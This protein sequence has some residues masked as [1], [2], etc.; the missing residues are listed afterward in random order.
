LDNTSAL[1]RFSLSSLGLGN[2]RRESWTT[3]AAVA[4]VR[5]P[6]ED[7]E[8]R[9]DVISLV[10]CSNECV[11]VVLENGWEEG[12]RRGDLLAEFVQQGWGSSTS[13]E[14]GPVPEAL[15]ETTPAGRGVA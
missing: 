13:A 4:G 2:S 5:R 11:L 3:A 9:R 7:W 1:Q 15:D 8:L 14:G 6:N 12:R 10:S